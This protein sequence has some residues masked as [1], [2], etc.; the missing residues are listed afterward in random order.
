MGNTSRINRYNYNR[1]V[2]PHACGEH[3]FVHQIIEPAAGS[4]PR[5]WGTRSLMV[6]WCPVG[7]FIPTHVG[8]TQPEH[9]SISVLSVHPHACGEHQT[10]AGGIWYPGGSSPRMWGTR[11]G[12]IH[13]F[14]YGRFI[15][16]HVGNTLM[17]T[18]YFPSSAVHP[19]ACGEHLL[20]S[21]NFAIF[22]G[23]SPRMWGT[24]PAP[25]S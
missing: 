16:T 25:G 4:S 10:E 17:Y 22:H 2:H 12:S 14:L 7:R 18:R 20:N 11:S 24:P 23:S 6:C 1:S 13:C 3:H 5:M 19:H 15:P 9:P 8:N 21:H